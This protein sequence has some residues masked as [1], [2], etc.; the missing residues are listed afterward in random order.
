MKTKHNDRRAMRARTG[1]VSAVC[2]RWACLAVAVAVGIAA[3]PAHAGKR[4]PPPPEL[5]PELITRWWLDPWNHS[6]QETMFIGWM[7]ASTGSTAWRWVMPPDQVS[8]LYVWWSAAIWVDG[9]GR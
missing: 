5:A 1:T 4:Q 8:V 7:D 9:F 2:A 6:M 3:P